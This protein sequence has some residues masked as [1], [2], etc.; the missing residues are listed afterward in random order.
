MSPYQSR[1]VAFVFSAVLVVLAY[2]TTSVKLDVT[3]GF[4]AFLAWYA[5]ARMALATYDD[6]TSKP[7]SLRGP[8]A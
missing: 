8:T 1:L 2:V 3:T 6:L 7:N 4:G 5:I